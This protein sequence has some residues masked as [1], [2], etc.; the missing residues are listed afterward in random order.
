[1]SVTPVPGSFGPAS[2]SLLSDHVGTIRY[3]SPFF[4]ISHM[5]LPT[6][7]KTLLK[8]CE[9]YFISNPLI[10]SVVYKMSEYPVTDLII[11]SSDE[12]LRSKWDDFFKLQLKFKKFQVEAGLDYNCY[13]NCFIS[14]NY[15]FKKFL[16]CSNCGHSMPI[17]K[18]SYI[19]RNF[20]YQGSCKKCGHYGEFKAQDTYVK[21]WRDIHLIRWSPERITIRH[22]EL[23]GKN[24]YYYSIPT[25]LKNDIQMGKKDIIE[26]TP[27]S[28]IEA[29]KQNK[30][31]I[32]NP[33]NIFHMKRP[34][35]AQKDKGWGLSMI[36]PVLKDVFYLQILR[37]AQEAIAV[38]HIVPLRVLFP[39]VASGSSDPYP[40]TNLSAWKKQIEIEIQRWRLDNNYIPILPIPIGQ[41]TLGAQGRA[42]MLSQEYRVWAEHIVAGMGVPNEFIFGGL[43]YSGSSVSLRMLENHFLDYKSDHINLVNWI[44]ERVGAFMSWVPAPAYFRRFKM[45]D[46]LQ[47]SAFNLQLNQAGK[48]SDKTLLE[49]TEWDADAERKQ[50]AVEQEL[51]AESQLSQAVAQ[52]QIQGEAQLTGIKYQARAQKVMSE[53]APGTPMEQ[54]PQEGQESPEMPQSGVP[55]AESP[56]TPGG[57]PIEKLVQSVA[58]Q[59]DQLDEAT[60]AQYIAQ[61]QQE[62]PM[63]WELVA[64]ALAER[65]GAH[66]SSAQSPDPQQKAPRRGPESTT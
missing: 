57:V 23:V 1:M 24:T 65:Q 19:F 50:I 58:A 29:M 22:N 10:N 5:Y 66:Q 43:S 30:D 25:T 46:D 27:T 64:P 56:V 11:D 21:S 47:R 12:N 7:F 6:S 26:K 54:Q 9:Y 52:S 60:R 41:Q 45:A 36:L 4:D 28:F 31:V 34:T 14:V 55:G 13:G 63:F 37:K 2:R 59:L 32:F 39:Q 44:M 53:L 15:P 38:E 61:I 20:G 62:N 33:N 16:V 35:I 40:T 3:P 51:L 17:E 48:I 8:W 49:D 18:T 42:L